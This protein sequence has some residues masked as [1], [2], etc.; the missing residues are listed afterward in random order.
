MID[1]GTRD[2]SV[3]DEA[4]APRV[5]LLDDVREIVEEV[6]TIFL[7]R[8]VPAV[9]ACDLA[10]AIA[11]LERFETLALVASDIRLGDEEGADIIS[12][13]AAHPS[14][15]DRGI[16]F[17]FMTGDVMRFAEGAMIDGHPLLLK[18][19]QPEQLLDISFA[20]LD[21]QGQA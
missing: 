9:G 7:L 18:P 11:M 8:G 14:L 3:S 2:A 21:A 16:A 4:F 10:E 15:A 12:L 1:N 19:V 13:V 6:C 20:L 5:L 17:L